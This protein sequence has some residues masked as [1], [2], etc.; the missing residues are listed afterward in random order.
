[1]ASICVYRGSTWETTDSG[2]QNDAVAE[3]VILLKNHNPK[4]VV[5]ICLF[6][7]YDN[8]STSLFLRRVLSAVP[9][10]ISSLIPTIRFVND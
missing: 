10:G 9:V 6:V 3:K 5:V 7:K 8:V 1:M 2:E 4:S